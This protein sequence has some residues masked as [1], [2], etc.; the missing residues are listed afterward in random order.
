MQREL[1]L[2]PSVSMTLMRNAVLSCGM[3]TLLAYPILFL[4]LIAPPLWLS[5]LPPTHSS[6]TLKSIDFDKDIDPHMMVVAAMGNLRA[7]NYSI[8]EAD[9]HTARGIAGK[10]IPAIATTTAMV[11]GFICLEIFK[12]LLKKPITSLLNTSCNLALPAFLCNEPQPP[13]QR[14]A[15]INGKEFHWNQW[16]RIDIQDTRMT[17][18]SLIEYLQVNYNV[19]LI[20]LSYGVSIL[21]SDYMNKKKME[22]RKGMAIQD[23]I[24][25]IT[26]KEFNMKQKY[27]ILEMITNDLESE[28]EVEL[29]YLRFRLFD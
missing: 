10:I 13:E 12:I 14:K 1:P 8:P 4:I 22:E 24:I 26:K 29:P 17:L 9:L 28:E 2:P 21:F 25:Q 19:Q 23:I 6:D 20:M 27:I 15:I 5:L 3:L 11:T 18:N 16:D 7:R